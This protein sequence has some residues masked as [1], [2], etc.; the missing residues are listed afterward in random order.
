[1]ASSGWSAFVN[2]TK[3]VLSPSPRTG[4][5]AAEHHPHGLDVVS[6]GDHPAIDIVALHGLNGHREKT[7]TASNGVH[8]LRDLLPEDLPQARILCWGYDA[9]T[10]ASGRVSQE[11]LYGHAALIHSDGAR[12]D[13]FTQHRSIKLS[14]Y[15]ILFMGTPHQGGNGVQL[16]RVLANVASLVTA[17]DDRLLKH[18]ERDSEWLQQQQGQYGPISDDFVTK[19]AYEEYTTPTI[20]G[21]SIMVVP[22]ASAVVPGHANAE[23]IAMHA[24]HTTMVRYASKQDVGYVTVSEHLQIMAEDATERVQQRWETQARVDEARGNINRF[25]LSVSLSEVAEV[26]NFVAREVELAWMHQK[27]SVSP[28][29]QTIVVHGLGGIGK[30]Q[31]TIAYIKRHRND[32]S[33][34]IWLNA[35]DEA[36]LKQSF[37]AAALSISQQYPTLSYMQS[38]VS[39]KDGDASLAVK[40][41]LD[42]PKNDRWLLILDNYDHPNIGGYAEEMSPGD[43]GNPGRHG[44]VDEQAPEGYDVRQYLP[45]T[46]QG[47]VIVTTRSSIVQI[48]ELL[49]LQK[50][51]KIEDSLRILETTSGRKDSRDDASAIALARKLDG[52]PLALSTA[53]SYL[54]QVSTSWLQYLQDYESA[55][56]PL[57][58]LSPQLLTY[59]NR[60]MYSTWN[61]SYASI[62]RRNESAAMLLRLWAFFDNEDLWYEL[63]QRGRLAGGP[64]WLRDLTETRLTFEHGMRELCNHGL[65]EAHFTAAQ[66]GA[67]SR[68]YSVHSCVHSWMVHVLNGPNEQYLPALAMECIG[69]HV[70]GKEIPQYWLIQRRLVLHA[71]RCRQL[72][73][74][75]DDDE[76]NGHVTAS[77]GL[78]YA[79]RGRFMEA[80]AMYDRALQT[81]EKAWGPE[82]TSTLDIVNNLAIVYANQGRPEKAEDMYKRALQGKKKA[83]G[84]EHTSTLDTVNNFATFC[85]DQRWLKK[86]ESMFNQALE[87]YKKAWG[88]EHISTLNAINNLAILYRRQKQPEEA[89]AM[90]IQAIQGYEKVCGPEHTSTL[91]AVNNLASLYESEKRLEEAEA[92][93]N[94]ALRGKEK[95]LGPDHT[96]TLITVE[97]LANLYTD[98]ERFEKAEAMFNWALEGYEKALGPEHISTLDIVN[99]LADLYADQERFE[100]AEVMF[101]RALEGYQKALALEDTTTFRPFIQAITNLGLFYDFVGQETRAKELFVEALTGVQLVFGDDSDLAEFL[102]QQLAS[103]PIE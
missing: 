20:L 97:N 82:H 101:I 46:D 48:G 70:P 85:A 100:E 6:E 9:N 4:G 72:L 57:Q 67:E 47:M 83:W 28:G 86:A 15:G 54:S 38:A 78:L 84:E 76:S 18:L 79:N 19:Y 30:T 17:A 11:Y 42:E 50:L 5:Q 14:T 92:M 23:P 34:S 35:R 26:G 49:R 29:R 63:V 24:N 55:W 60:A 71:D 77:L 61:I 39:D 12:P 31:L 21:H 13:A 51:C 52:L 81:Y 33:A 36:S 43:D 103:R 1:M 32:Y 93:Y 22:K 2:R 73:S 8:W 58:K 94:Q 96:S 91:N 56:V 59:E 16:A 68:G 87:G 74:K 75:V 99:N 10:H 88:P 44:E 45:R 98:Q 25:T 3:R 53:G 37:R 41:W 95:A 65:V 69:L 64:K 66:S 27:L 62:H 102:R 90:Y 80:E 7:W 89:E 40:R